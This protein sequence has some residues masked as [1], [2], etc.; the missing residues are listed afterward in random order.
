MAYTIP[1]A[2]KLIAFRLR[3]SGINFSNIQFQVDRYVLDDFY[4][5]NY[6]YTTKTY[7]SGFETT[8]DTLPKNTGSIVA[9]VTYGSVIEF[10]QIN[11]RPAEAIR[12]AGGIDGKTDFQIGDTLIFVQQEGYYNAGPYDGWV[13][14]TNAYLGDDILTGAVE[15]YDAST[16]DTYS[17]IPGFL[18]KAQ[19]TSAQNQRGGVWQ[20]G[21]VNGIVNLSFVCEIEL[22]QRV[23]ILRGSTYAGAIMYYN[24][25]LTP[26]QS[27]PF[28]TVYKLQ[29][30]SVKR[31]TT[32]NDNT[33]RFFTKRDS[34]YEPGTQDKYLKFPQIGAFH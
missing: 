32:F 31:K 26:G 25:I 22:N 18:E 6:N 12:Q 11:G 23:Q 2:S 19:G 17:V 4:S 30:T 33:T 13:N 21:I 20:I 15:G 9:T 24:P 1:G 16:Y 5:T 14:Y 7:N 29:P 27:V 28:Y 34:Y 3:N 8:F 10:S